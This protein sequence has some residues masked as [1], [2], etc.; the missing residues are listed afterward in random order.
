VYCASSR[1]VDVRYFRAAEQLGQ[2]L[3][4]NGITLVY[5]GGGAG[6]M[7]ALADGALKEGGRVLG[8]LPR[9]MNDVEWG[10]RGLTELRLVR[11]LHERKRL[12]IENV[13]AVVAL[14]GGTGTLEELFEVITLKRLGLYIKPIVLVNTG[15]FF[16]PLVSFLEGIIREKF[17]D[18]RH[19]EMWCLVK[20][21]EEVV[22]AIQ[23]APPWSH[24]ARG[25]ALV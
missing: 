3:A 10:H 14:P 24:E 11:D 22:Q 7:G 15:G 21:A 1:K 16:D 6:L 13:D 25:F 17:M 9:F 2:L 18:A 4:R 23:Q 5:G 19:R 8:I 12:M 20:D